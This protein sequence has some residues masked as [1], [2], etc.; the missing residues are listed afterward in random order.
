MILLLPASTPEPHFNLEPVREEITKLHREITELGELSL[1]KAIRLGGMLVE[2]QKPLKHSRKYGDWINANLPFS[3][4]TARDYVTLF[5]NREQIEHESDADNLSIR[6]AL[7]FIADTAKAVTP[8]GIKV[9]PLEMDVEA[10]EVH[11]NV[12]EESQD[13][14]VHLVDRAVLMVEASTGFI[15]ELIGL[16][17]AAQKAGKDIKYQ[18]IGA[19]DADVPLKEP[20]REILGQMAAIKTQQ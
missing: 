16:I 2:V 15:D 14:E 6:A 3:A 19:F 20:F 1:R 11:D 7:K 18:K 5:R 12:P 8:V 9:C 17:R 10:K 13:E 4:R